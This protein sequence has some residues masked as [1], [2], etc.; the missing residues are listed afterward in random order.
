MSAIVTPFSAAPLTGPVAG[1]DKRVAVF[2]PALAGGGAERSMVNLCGGFVRRGAGVDLVLGQAEGPYLSDLDPAIRVIDLKATGVLPKLRGL[3][4]YLKREQPCGLISVLDNINLA[5][6]AKR[7]AGAKSRIV[8]NVQNNVSADLA[9]HRGLKGALKPWLMRKTYPWA[10]NVTCVSG[11]VA[12]DLASQA[13]FAPQQLK[14]I[15]NPVRLDTVRQLALEP[16]SHPWLA[17]ESVPVI[18]AAGR[19]T[20]QKDYPT[21]LKA[22]AMLRRDRDVRLIILGEGELRGELE[23]QIKALSLTGAVA[24]P[25]FT[26]NPY[27][28]MARCSLFVMS[29]AWEG[30][31]TVMIEALGCGA[32]VVSTDCPSGPREILDK[33]KFGRLVPV[34]DAD[35]LAAAMG[36][37]L[38]EPKQTDRSHARADDFAAD[39]IVDQ[40]LE[41]FGLTGSLNQGGFR[42]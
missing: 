36:A 10:D 32:T 15:Y 26:A 27:A 4:G 8:I 6:F 41:L 19:L 1:H 5:A 29:S 31:P 42:A 38:D 37:S 33:G 7:L 20:Q 24:L 30:L 3:A 21:L 16:A 22:F 14:V 25:G 23:S 39:K 12:D 40:Y 11:G 13:C 17:D 18:V 28:F 34:G 35:A 9:S 2:L